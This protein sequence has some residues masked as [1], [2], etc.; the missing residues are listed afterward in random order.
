MMSLWATLFVVEDEFHAEPVGTFPNRE[1]ALSFVGRLR[2]DPQAQKY[3]APCS[4]WR[5]CRREYSLAGVRGLHNALDALGPEALFAI[6]FKHGD[7]SS[8]PPV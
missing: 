2:A 4:S 6:D 3:K 7:V 8:L 5:T 1:E